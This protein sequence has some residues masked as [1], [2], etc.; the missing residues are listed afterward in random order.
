M[1]RN[2]IPR[3]FQMRRRATGIPTRSRLGM[4]LVVGAWA[5]TLL[6]CRPATTGKDETGGAAAIW[7]TSVMHAA[8][9]AAWDALRSG[10]S[11]S[12]A[13]LS[14]RPSGP[15]YV[16]V[17]IDSEALADAIFDAECCSASST[18]YCASRQDFDARS[19]ASGGMRARLE[20]GAKWAFSR[21]SALVNAG[22]EDPLGIAGLTALGDPHRES[23]LF[24]PFSTEPDLLTATFSEQGRGCSGLRVESPIPDGGTW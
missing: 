23:F 17:E 20:S 14:K 15:Y 5:L 22:A 16:L 24:G 2:A 19:A 13:S 1:S 11:V 9:A 7:A 21:E 8:E 4:C 18:D 6:G 3:N 10:E 12:N